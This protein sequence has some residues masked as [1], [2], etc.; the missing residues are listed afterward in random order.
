MFYKMIEAK[1]NEWLA[2]ETCT[3]KAVIDY[4]VKTGQMR[5]AQVEAI[6]TY[7]FL[8]IACSCKPLAELFYEG[9]FNTL[10]LDDSEVSHSTRE[11]LK[12]NKAAAALFEYA[13]LTND[14]G[15][16]VSPKLEQQMVE[17]ARRLQT[18][19]GKKVYGYLRKPVKAQA[20]AHRG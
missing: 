16:Q 7:L 17:L 2:S 14:A 8:K 18:V 4:I 11:Y 12:V 19:K 1:R 13:C 20:D 3:V 5:D 9:A 15:E 10:D 6:K